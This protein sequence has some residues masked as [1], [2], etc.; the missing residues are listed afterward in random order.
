ML[1]KAPPERSLENQNKLEQETNLRA[2][3][4]RRVSTFAGVTENRDKHFSDKAAPKSEGELQGGEKTS[5]EEEESE[6][7][8]TPTDKPS[9]AAGTVPASKP[10][11]GHVLI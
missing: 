10:G 5:T 6:E 7:S 4:S 2:K 8:G 1:G 3:L 11:K 9:A